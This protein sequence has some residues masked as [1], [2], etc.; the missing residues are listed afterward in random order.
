[1]AYDDYPSILKYFSGNNPSKRRNWWRF[2]NI[3]FEDFFARYLIL[4]TFCAKDAEAPFPFGSSHF[5]KCLCYF[6][7]FWDDVALFSKDSLLCRDSSTSRNA[8]QFPT[9]SNLGSF[10][11]AC[12]SLFL[13][14]QGP[15]MVL[16]LLSPTCRLMCGLRNCSTIF[17]NKL[18]LTYVEYLKLGFPMFLDSFLSLYDYWKRLEAAEE[19]CSLLEF[20]KLLKD[21]CT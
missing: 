8:G 15:R 12:V 10:Y 7:Y 17:R 19:S 6:F 16:N 11:C 20:S 13:E 21:A 4:W 2:R 5:L 3:I 9:S 14:E 1:M 18:S